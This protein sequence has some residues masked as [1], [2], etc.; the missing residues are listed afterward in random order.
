MIRITEHSKHTIFKDSDV[1]VNG[2][3]LGPAAFDSEMYYQHYVEIINRLAELEDQ[4]CTDVVER[5]RWIPVEE[6]LPEE[7]SKAVIVYCPK[8]HNMFLATIRNG[9]WLSFDT[10][11]SV[12]IE[13]DTVYGKVTHWMPLLEPPKEA[14]E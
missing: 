3:R 5:P 1:M 6:R 10:Q 7:F 13:D 4:Y 9:K 12:S 14:T 11:R 2:V 8:Y